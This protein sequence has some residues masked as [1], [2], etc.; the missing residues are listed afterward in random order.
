MMMASFGLDLVSAFSSVLACLWNV[1]PGLESV[2]AVENYAHIPDIGKIVLSLCMIMGRLEIFTVI[3][4]FS[5]EFWR[6]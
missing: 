4:L 2:G 1:G 6:K 3:I 5:P